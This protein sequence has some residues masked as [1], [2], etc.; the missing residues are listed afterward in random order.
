M[1]AAARWWAIEHSVNEADR[2]LTGFRK[3]INSLASMPERCPVANESANFAI[4]LRELY[5]GV[6]GRPTHRAVF[7]IRG[8]IVAVLA[9][10]HGAQD[11]LTPDD[12]NAPN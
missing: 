9:V 5:F 7:M 6:R 12:L 11:E 8:T 4:E 2:W 10:R 1:E 3:K